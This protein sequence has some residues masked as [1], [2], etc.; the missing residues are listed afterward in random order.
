MQSRSPAGCPIHLFEWLKLGRRTTAN[1]VWDVKGLEL[2]P[3]PGSHECKRAEAL[4]EIVWSSRRKLKVQ[5]LHSGVYPRGMT[6][7]LHVEIRI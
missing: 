6:T 5:P 3:T 2:S 4:R 1:V 7:Q